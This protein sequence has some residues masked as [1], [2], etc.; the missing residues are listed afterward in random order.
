MTYLN[1]F[2]V[3]VYTGDKLKTRH[4]FNVP[5]QGKPSKASVR[6]YEGLMELVAYAESEVP[7]THKGAIRIAKDDL[8]LFTLTIILEPKEEEV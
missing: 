6:R 5:A 3:I 2:P 4:V 8:G 7:G 1:R